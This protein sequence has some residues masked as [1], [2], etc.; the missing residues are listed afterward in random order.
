MLTVKNLNKGETLYEKF[1]GFTKTF[2][3]IGNSIK[4]S[5]DKYDKALGQ[6]KEGKGNLVTQANQLR[7]LGLKSDKRVSLGLLPAGE[8]ET[9]DVEESINKM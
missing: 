3:D 7:N 2:E 4:A 9:E 6:L 1:V 5:Q 8:D